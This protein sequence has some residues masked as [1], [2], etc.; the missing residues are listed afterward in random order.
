MAENEWVTGKVVLNVRGVPLDL[1]MTVP[2]NPVKP[3]RMLPIF[4]QMASTFTDVGV[5]AVESKGKSISCKAGC[6][7]CC[8]QPVPI[9]EI[10]VYQIAELVDAMP[11]PRRSVIRKRFAD[12]M[13]H[14]RNSG[15]LEDLQ[16]HYASG[17]VK[18]SR[19]EALD[20]LDAAMKFFYEGIP[21]PFLEDESCSIH[22]NRPMICRE[23]LVTS[24][25]VNCSKPSADTIDRVPIPI[26]P[27][28]TVEQLARTG[29]MKAEEPIM[30]V[31]ALELAEK[32]PEAFPEKP[33]PEWMTDFF[34]KL[35]QKDV[36]EDPGSRGSSRR[37][38]KKRKRKASRV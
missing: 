23:Y 22:P 8:R 4:Q 27:S 26:K 29:R 35:T 31:M 7:A 13:A 32:Y 25:A 16:R 1:E 34:S 21:C 24:P 37:A 28:N 33:G 10:E 11:E 12:A 36:K 20:A 2:A 9:S 14:F 6:G 3:H 38:R 18:K 30:L 19:E 5:K 15:L 17:R